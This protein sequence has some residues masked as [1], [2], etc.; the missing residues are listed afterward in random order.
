M[1]DRDLDENA[2]EG[3][4]PPGAGKG[5]MAVAPARRRRRAH[6]AK[7]KKTEKAD[8]P[9][10]PKRNRAP[11]TSAPAPAPSAPV[12]EEDEGRRAEAQEKSKDKTDDG[13][14]TKTAARPR[15]E[16][17]VA[18]ANRLF[19]EGRWAEAARAYRELLRRDPT[20]PTPRAGGS[21]WRLRKPPPRRRLPQPRHLRPAETGARRVLP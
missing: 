10:E 16:P 12:A 20:T 3:A 21:G 5:R 7:A 14:E 18:H 2:L 1:K 13:P 19:A 17:P 8:S 9:M 4:A 11:A 15:A 6:A